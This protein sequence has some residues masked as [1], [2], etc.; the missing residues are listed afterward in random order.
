[1]AAAE[2]FDPLRI[3]PYVRLP[4]PLPADTRLTPPRLGRA[5]EGVPAPRV[6]RVLPAAGAVGAGGRHRTATGAVRSGLRRRHREFAGL[7]AGVA[8]AAALGT[9]AVTGGLLAGDGGGTDLAV[10]DFG[11]RVSA[12]DPGP[13]EESTDTAAPVPGSAQRQPGEQA[14][15]P[16]RADRAE[17][18]GGSAGSAGGYARA[19][20]PGGPM[21]TPSVSM[22]PVV[23]LTEVPVDPLAPVAPPSA[24]KETSGVI[25]MAAEDEPTPPE[26]MLPPPVALVP[27][28]S[29]HPGDDGA[30]V[31]ELQLRLAQLG[32]F[33]GRA[34]GVYGKRVEKA[35][36]A[37]QSYMAVTSDPSGVYGPETRRW[38]EAATVEPSM[39]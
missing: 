14:G 11:S 8:A 36:R 37:Y 26:A 12:P 4:E 16:A 15:G 23:P 28:P 3:R 6:T 20:G 5:V 24:A 35:V 39:K 19:T 34:D 10:P 2:D 32:L 29:L 9:S 18:P 27:Q 17:A 7:A 38:L 25:P 30:E 1:M 31:E 22:P 33:H 21:A 13:V